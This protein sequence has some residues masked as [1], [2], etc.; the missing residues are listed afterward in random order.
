MYMLLIM[1]LILDDV[2]QNSLPCKLEI[3]SSSGSELEENNG[4]Q[5]NAADYH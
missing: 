2:W 4:N 5:T 3:F 1:L